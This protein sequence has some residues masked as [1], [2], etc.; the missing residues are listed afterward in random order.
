M[1]GG[2]GVFLADTANPIGAGIWLYL[3]S[4]YICSCKPPKRGDRQQTTCQWQHS[5]LEVLYLAQ[6]L[7]EE[8]NALIEAEKQEYR[9]IADER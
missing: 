6:E 8:F 1:A 5:R 4:R 9:P 3:Y 7:V 2:K